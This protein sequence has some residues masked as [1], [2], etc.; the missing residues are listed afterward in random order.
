MTV[1]KCEFIIEIAKC[2]AQIA[3]SNCWQKEVMLQH[4]PYVKKYFTIYFE[5][6]NL[7]PKYLRE[8]PEIN[9]NFK[10]STNFF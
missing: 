9:K 10:K 3:S 7:S 4:R 8:F 5:V 2:I 6:I 1:Q